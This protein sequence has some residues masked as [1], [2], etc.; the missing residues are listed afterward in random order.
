MQ[1]I[2]EQSVAGRRGVKL[3]CSDVP[4]APE[5]LAAYSGA[6]RATAQASV[7]ATADFLNIFNSLHG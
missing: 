3:P 6:L 4:A 2:Y 7:N 5:P 1:L